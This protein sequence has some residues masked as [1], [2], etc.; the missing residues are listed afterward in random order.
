MTTLLPP[1]TPFKAQKVPSQAPTNT[2]GVPLI[3]VTAGESETS[4][5]R[6]ES[7]LRLEGRTFNK[8]IQFPCCVLRCGLRCSFN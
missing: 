2:V 4:P 3:V 5:P 7:P 6:L 1:V 8:L